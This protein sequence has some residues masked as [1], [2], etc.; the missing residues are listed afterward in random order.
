[1]LKH[2]NMPTLMEVGPPPSPVLGVGG[3]FGRGLLATFATPFSWDI[4]EALR[5]IKFKML[6]TKQF[7]GATDPDDHLYVYKAQMYV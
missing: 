6:S 2:N 7:D 3:S 4:I 5:P 1:M